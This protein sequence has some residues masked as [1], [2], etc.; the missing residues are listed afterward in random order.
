MLLLR[1]YLD[2]REESIN[3]LINKRNP[4]NKKQIEKLSFIMN[5]ADPKQFIAKNKS[6]IYTEIFVKLYNQKNRGQ[7]HKIHRIIQLKRQYTS[8]AQNFHIFG[9]YFIIKIFSVLRNVYVMLRDQET[10]VVY[11]NNYID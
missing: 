4:Q 2:R 3:E 7:V 5:I 10:I 8:M 1:L 6:N 11:A 9:A